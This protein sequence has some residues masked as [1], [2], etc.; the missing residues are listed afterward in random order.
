MRVRSVVLCLAVLCLA[1][2]MFADSSPVKAGKWEFSFQMEIPGMPFKIPPVKTT[3]CV[4]EEDAQSAIPQDKNNKDCKVGDYKTSGNTIS[5]T[6]DCPKQ[7]T[8]GEGEITYDGDTMD[9]SMKL[10]TDGTEST[11]KYSGKYLGKCDK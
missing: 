9:G 10:T 1:V 8:K 7:K 5:W 4:T 2:P 11:T 6:V 3:H